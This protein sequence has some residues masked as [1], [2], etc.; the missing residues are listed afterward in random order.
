MY[1]HLAKPKVSHES[2]ASKEHSLPSDPTGSISSLLCVL[3]SPHSSLFAVPGVAES[4]PASPKGGS[5][6]SEHTSEF[7]SLAPPLNI[8]VKDTKADAG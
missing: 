1:T 6:S 2:K 3:P 4:P 7:P 8:F 5:P